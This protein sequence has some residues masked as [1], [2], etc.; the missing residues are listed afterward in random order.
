MDLARHTS[1]QKWDAILIPD[2]E[3]IH[4]HSRLKWVIIEAACSY[5]S[6]TKLFSCERRLL[7]S[8]NNLCKQFGA[9]SGPTEFDQ[10]KECGS[11][12]GPPRPGG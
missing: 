6:L 9:I 12:F 10:Y 8:T 7:S 4:I 3:V 2:N 11:N 1:P 5:Y